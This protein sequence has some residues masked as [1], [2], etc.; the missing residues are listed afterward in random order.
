MV[1]VCDEIAALRDHIVT[2]II[3]HEKPGICLLL[4]KCSNLLKIFIRQ[5]NQLQI[6]LHILLGAEGV[7]LIQDREF[8]L[9]TG[10]RL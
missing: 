10:G 5:G 8:R 3:W 6:I 7:F 4:F 1:S 2:G 9:H